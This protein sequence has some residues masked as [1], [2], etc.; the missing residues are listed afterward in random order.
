M[1][2]NMAARINGE[3]GSTNTARMGGAA[4]S[5]TSEARRKST[6][7]S[8]S[9]VKIRMQSGDIDGGKVLWKRIVGEESTICIK[10][11]GDITAWQKNSISVR[12]II[13]DFCMDYSM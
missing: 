10:F 4:G 12:R 8:N 7:R 2:I 1:A 11:A 5:S 13:Q 9:A 6:A 3:A